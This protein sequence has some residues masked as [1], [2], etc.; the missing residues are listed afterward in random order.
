MHCH[1]RSIIGIEEEKA[2]LE[3]LGCDFDVL[4]LVITESPSHLRRRSDKETGL[5]LINF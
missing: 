2:A 3:R 5:A 4:E 1:Q